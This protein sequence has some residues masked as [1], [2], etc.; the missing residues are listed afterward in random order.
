[1]TRLLT[2][3][4]E[5]ARSGYHEGVNLAISTRQFVG[6]GLTEDLSPAERHAVQA[7]SLV[8]ITGCLVMGLT[9][10]LV[11]ARGFTWVAIVYAVNTASFAAVLYLNHRRLHTV[12][13]ATALALGNLGT[14]GFTFALGFEAGV[15]QFYS[16]GL[17]IPF[18]VFKPEARRLRWGFALLA[19]A[20][21]LL[22]T[23][24]QDSL[25]PGWS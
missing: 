17:I 10:P 11:L 6:L 19:A 14:A 9:V 2:T 22:T 12:A 1:M 8:A 13:A 18:L 24:F 20:G 21:W 7:T 5:T 16:L 15:P 4:K 3:N 23:W 25:P